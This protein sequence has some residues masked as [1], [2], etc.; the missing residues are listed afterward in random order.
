MLVTRIRWFKDKWEKKVS[1][2]L[3][4][5]GR[6]KQKFV[7]IISAILKLYKYCGKEKGE[8]MIHF[9][10]VQRVRE[11]LTEVVMYKMK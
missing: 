2:D 4:Y 11:S 5:N 7:N 8:C 1:A 6:D 10:G 3:K 9:L